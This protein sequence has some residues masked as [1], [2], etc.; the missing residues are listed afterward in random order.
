MEAVILFE[1]NDKNKQTEKTNKQNKYTA[2]WIHFSQ[3]L[4][5]E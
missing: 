4:F 5:A 1:D 3:G 2:G